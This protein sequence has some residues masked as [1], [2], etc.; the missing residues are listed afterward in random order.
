MTN[1]QRILHF[2]I[3]KIV[4]G[5]IVC[6]GSVSV[7]QMGLDQLLNITSVHNDL[8]EFI[9]VLSTASIAMIVYSYLFKFYEKRPITEL[10][11]KGIFKN[12]IYGIGLGV[13]LQSLTI[14]V[15]YLNGEY[16]IVTLNQS[17][18]YFLL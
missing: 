16:S 13:L 11:T 14:L 2:P 5:F 4:F 10:Y 12:L 1:I 15:I 7:I 17:Y 6:M 18:L 9:I 8:K 3:T